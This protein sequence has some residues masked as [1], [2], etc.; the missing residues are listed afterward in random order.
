MRTED[1]EDDAAQQQEAVTR[2]VEIDAPAERVW[3]SLTTSEGRQS[4][5]EDDPNRVIVVERE[6]PVHRISWWWFSD[7]EAARHVDIRVVGIPTGTR[8]LVTETAPASFP[9]AAMAAA[10]GSMLVAA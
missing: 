4:W 9:L 6:E 3:E 7:T 1:L 8:V 5:L 10:T 2:E